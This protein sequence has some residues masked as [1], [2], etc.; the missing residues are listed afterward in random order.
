MGA[1]HRGGA[2]D[3]PPRRLEVRALAVLAALAALAAAGC[4][5][6]GGDAEERRDP[7]EIAASAAR[8]RSCT[9]WPRFRPHSAGE[10]IGDLPLT[11]AEWYCGGSDGYEKDP[12]LGAFVSYAYGDCDPP[13]G[14][15][16]CTLPVEIQSAPL[17]YRPPAI[18]ELP[19]RLELR[20]VPARASRDG[21]AIELYTGTTSVSVAGDD[22]RTI[23]RAAEALRPAG[24]PGA[25]P[26]RKLRRPDATQLRRR[27][28]CAFRRP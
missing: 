26:P 3:R 22:P 6:G 13:E 16:G 17:C 7:R 1:A 19:V 27:T 18:S 5:D 21:R 25:A 9:G 4:H 23:R 20:G 24:P 12:E 28:E 11:D 8:E 10:R 15:G 14:E 2:A